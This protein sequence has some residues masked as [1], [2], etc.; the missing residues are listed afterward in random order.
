MIRKI[1]DFIISMAIFAVYV[2]AIIAGS[3]INVVARLKRQEDS[4]GK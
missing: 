3:L 4:G 1:K 2:M